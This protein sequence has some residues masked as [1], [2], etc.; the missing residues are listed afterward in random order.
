[1]R[2]LRLAKGW[3]Q[4]EAAD[5]AGVRREMWA[6]YEAGAEPGAR[7]LAALAEA[8]FDALYVL[9]GKRAK[10]VENVFDDKVAAFREV[11]EDLAHAGVG[12]EFREAAFI[13]R[14]RAYATEPLSPAA[15]RDG[16]RDALTP[17]ER[18]L[19][20]NYRRSSDAGKD[21]LDKTSAAM[22]Q[23]SVTERKAG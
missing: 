15:I 10:P 19:L 2:E 14:Q 12:P 21:A 20:D 8:G 6:K 16:P 4:Q 23:P 11:N 3:S 7:A 9:T 18:A 17:R 5:L 13:A 22:A 1:M